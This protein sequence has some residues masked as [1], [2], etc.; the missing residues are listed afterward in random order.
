MREQAQNDEEI[1]LELDP[2][3]KVGHSYSETGSHGSS[4]KG[5][6][7]M[8]LIPIGPQD[9]GWCMKCLTK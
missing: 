3:K 4:S 2:G 1:E 8:C 7:L 6:G 5:Q 9:L